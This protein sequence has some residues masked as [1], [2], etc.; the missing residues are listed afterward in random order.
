[1]WTTSIDRAQMQSLEILKE[2]KALNPFVWICNG[3]SI[4]DA[5]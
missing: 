3:Y 4:I 2:P 1:M 5:T